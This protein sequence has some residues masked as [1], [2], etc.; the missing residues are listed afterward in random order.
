M[1]STLIIN[2]GSGGGSG[3]ATDIAGLQK[4]GS[5]TFVA[6]VAKQLTFTTAFDAAKFAAKGY[7]VKIFNQDGSNIQDM[8]L[9]DNLATGV[10]VTLQES[11]TFAW[12]VT[13]K[14]E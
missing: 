5:A 7:V 12:E 6:G 14:T 2:L 9:S 8:A 10:K 3:I 4:T 13:L 11:G 1:G